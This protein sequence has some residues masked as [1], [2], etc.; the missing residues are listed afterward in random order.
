MTQLND[1]TKK[2]QKEF[3]LM[4]GIAPKDSL[5]GKR[6]KEVET[7]IS[8]ALEERDEVIVGM[9]KGIEKPIPEDKSV[10]KIA[11][12]CDEHYNLALKDLIQ[13]IQSDKEK[14]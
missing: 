1:H 11:I 7:F 2:V 9:I 10:G 3:R 5:K 6:G 13:L 8:K 4:W 12:W 14:V